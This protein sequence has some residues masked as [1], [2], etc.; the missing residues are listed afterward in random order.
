MISP[1]RDIL[2]D[3]RPGDVF[4]ADDRGLLY[5]DGVFRTLRVDAGQPRWWDEQV[6]KLGRDC[7][8]LGLVAPEPGVWLT[9]LQHLAL[10]PCNGILKLLVTRGSGERGY[11]PPPA[12]RT[13]RMMVFE[14]IEFSPDP[15][16]GLTLRVCVLRLGWQPRLAGVK[17]LNRLENV[18]ARAEWDAPEI[19]E[20][21]LL[22]Q[23]GKVISGVMSNLFIWQR[24]RLLTPRLDR[25][26]VA[27][28]ARDR[29]MQKALAAGIEVQET[30]LDLRAVYEAEEVMLTNSVRGLR[31][32]ARL[33]AQCW[34]DSVISQRLMDYLNA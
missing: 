18:L 31:R 17:H 10:P 15:P 27:G 12:A 4:P 23:S 3:G 25:C 6:A 7:A 28:L 24:N 19:D 32:V 8:S 16:T 34:P 9:D 21:L 20:G 2:V 30:E 22:D 26:G 11:R 1:L 29:L 5:G 33:E 14:A 13:R